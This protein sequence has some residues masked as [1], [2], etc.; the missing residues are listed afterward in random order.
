[1]RSGRSDLSA[2]PCSAVPNVDGSTSR[3]ATVLT[4]GA[5]AGVESGVQHELVGGRSGGVA[6]DIGV[7][8]AD[9]VFLESAAAA[10]EYVDTLIRQL[11]SS[12]ARY[13]NAAVPEQ[14]F[15]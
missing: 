15:R 14:T 4:P 9:L 2:I 13:L 8:N 3:V 1:M 5:C 11:Y 10:H 12:H 6:V 7:R